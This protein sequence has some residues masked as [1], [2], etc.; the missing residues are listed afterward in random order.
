MA[1][2]TISRQLG[3][4]GCEVAQAVADT[5]GYRLVWREVIHQAAQQADAPEVALEVIDEL[6]LLGIS[7]SLKARKAYF[8]A[9]HSLLHDWAAVGN[10]V[11]VGRAGQVILRDHPSAFHV[12]VIAPLEVRV[13][14]L[15]EEKQISPDASRA[16]IEASDRQR[17]SYLRRFYHVRWNDP[18]LYDLV[19]NTGRVDVPT[20]ATIITSIFSAER[21]NA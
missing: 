18:G 15:A 4:L 13:K 5:L 1:V 19:L 21:K 20:A 7:S 16:Q 6:G 3:S 2:I 9:I 11:I 17:R 12:Q 10:I 14:R 8:A